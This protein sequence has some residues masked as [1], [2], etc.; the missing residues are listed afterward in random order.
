MTLKNLLI[1]AAAVAT[2]AAPAVALADPGYFHGGYESRGDDHP[3]RGWG[4]GGGWHGGW[5]SGWGHGYRYGDGDG[6]RSHCWIAPRGHFDPWGR[7]V[8]R[9]VEVCR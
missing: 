3:Y 4:W 2:L 7:W 1:A 5:G 9:P 6:Y 8:V